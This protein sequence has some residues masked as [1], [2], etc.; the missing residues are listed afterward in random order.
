MLKP[1]TATGAPIA[2]SLSI[3]RC[4]VNWRITGSQGTIKTGVIHVSRIATPSINNNLEYRI[5]S[6]GNWIAIGNRTGL[7]VSIDRDAVFL[8]KERET[9]GWHDQIMGTCAR[10]IESYRVAW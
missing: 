5:V 4:I 10:N 7:G 2:R 3:H 1:T 9:I 8:I 6:C